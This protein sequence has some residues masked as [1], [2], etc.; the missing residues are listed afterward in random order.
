MP[1]KALGAKLVEE[2]VCIERLKGLHDKLDTI[3]L[4]VAKT[5]DLV[6]NVAKM[7]TKIDHLEKCVYGAIGLAVTSL[8]STLVLVLTKWMAK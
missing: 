6:V 4:N 7:E 3:N 5:L 8:C 1:T 2:D